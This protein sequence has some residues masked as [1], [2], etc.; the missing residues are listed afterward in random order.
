MHWTVS[1]PFLEAA[2]NASETKA[3]PT[4]R[5]ATAGLYIKIFKLI[6]ITFNLLLAGGTIYFVNLYRLP[7]TQHK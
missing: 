5:F 3:V 4:P 6:F 7:C 2:V 1:I